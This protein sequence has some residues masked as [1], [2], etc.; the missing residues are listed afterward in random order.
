MFIISVSTL[1][2]FAQVCTP[3]PGCLSGICPDSTTNLPVTDDN[4]TTYA[5]TV[6]VIVPEDTVSG[7]LTLEYQWIKIDSVKG[8]PPG[9]SYTCEPST[10]VF[11]G[12]DA[13]CIRI[14]GNPSSAGPGT[15]QIKAYVKAKLTHWLLG[16]FYGYDSVT[17]LRIQIDDAVTCGIPTGLASSSIGTSTA[18]VSWDNMG[19]TTY[20]LKYKL[21]TATAWTSINTTATSYNLT[22]LTA[23]SQYKWNVT[24]TCPGTG[25]FKSQTK[26]FTTT[27]CRLGNDAFYVDADEDLLQLYPN[28]AHDNVHVQFTADYDAVYQVM[29]TDINGKTVY[30]QELE[31]LEG[32]NTFEIPLHA[33]SKGIYL[34]KML[35]ADGQYVSRFIKE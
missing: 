32:D 19:A 1:S 9:F 16:T 21:S 33:F 29:I 10:C 23:C 26:K 25:N 8:L 2:V 15:Y 24:A 28:P 34:L 4:A 22:G 5:T 7:G 27:G 31:M 18:T 17:Y 13:S 35:H 3:D 14:S 20:K 30:T 12:N 6:T 11:P